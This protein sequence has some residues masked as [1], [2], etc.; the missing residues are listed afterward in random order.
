MKDAEITKA[1]RELTSRINEEDY[2]GLEKKL[3]S[4]GNDVLEVLNSDAEGA[5]SPIVTAGRLMSLEAIKMYIRYGADLLANDCYGQNALNNIRNALDVA[6]DPKDF[7]QLMECGIYLLQVKA[8]RHELLQY[9]DKFTL[10]LLRIQRHGA[11]LAKIFPYRYDICMKAIARLSNQ[12]REVREQGGDLLLQ[13]IEETIRSGHILGIETTSHIQLQTT[14]FTINS[15]GNATLFSHYYLHDILC[16]YVASD[17]LPLDIQTRLRFQEIIRALEHKNPVIQI[18]VTG[19]GE[20]DV[21]LARVKD[22]LVLSNRGEGFSVKTRGVKIFKLKKDIDL[23]D[24]MKPADSDEEFEDHLAE[25]AKI[26]IPEYRFRQIK[27]QK[28]GTCSFA[29]PKSLIAPILKLLGDE[30][31][32]GT[33]KKFTSWMRDKEIDHLLAKLTQARFQKHKV[34][35]EFYFDVLS[36]YALKVYIREQKT[37]KIRPADMARF[38]KIMD[39]FS[40]FG[41]GK[42]FMQTMY[43]TK[44]LEPLFDRPIEVKISPDRIGRDYRPDLLA[45]HDH[46]PKDADVQLTDFACD[47]Y[48]LQQQIFLNFK[49][50]KLDLIV[51]IDLAKRTMDHTE[52]KQY[53]KI[54]KYELEELKSDWEKFLHAVGQ[55]EVL[56]VARK[57]VAHRKKLWLVSS[58][59]SPASEQETLSDLDM[60]LK[61]RPEV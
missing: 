25:F 24:F 17:E 19:W 35:R 41:R 2:V 61:S 13:Y 60:L 20:H 51:L 15:E 38:D 48:A 18:M 57:Y 26:T 28:H 37:E 52:S 22:R 44:N 14:N 27:A 29:S 34:N 49:Q 11:S 40:R 5:Q 50:R 55:K 36:K 45:V 3:K 39:A 53:V 7:A 54:I 10:F 21:C 59:F 47:D 23:K 32:F 4:L 43:H 9:I 30:D 1:R 56:D 33:Y 6:Y 12:L 8:E 58:V 42:V 31:A 46:L 16:E